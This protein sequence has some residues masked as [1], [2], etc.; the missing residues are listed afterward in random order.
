MVEAGTLRKD[1][2]YRL[3]VFPVEVP[4][5]RERTEDIALF[6][7]TFL[8]RLN[9]SYS[10]EIHEIHPEAMEA[11]MSY[12]WPGNIRELE[13]LLER[14]YILETSSKITLES[15]PM[16]LVNYSGSHA[17]VQVDVST[18]LAEVRRRGADGVEKQYLK[19]LLSVHKGRIKTTAA[20]A[21]I[22]PRQLHKLMKKHDIQKEDFKLSG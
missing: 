22:T 1:L 2:Y 11:F 12:P 15:L 21:G 19:E 4:P 14:G 5:L 9:S 6:A 17:R 13:N 18:P 8:E 3:S 10:K 7:Q 16:E 20:A